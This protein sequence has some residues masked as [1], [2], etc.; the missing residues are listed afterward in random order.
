MRYLIAAAAL[1]GSVVIGTNSSAGERSAPLRMTATAYCDK[2]ATK[3]GVRAQTGVVAAD[4]RRLPLGTTLRIVAPREAPAGVYV[5]ADTGSEITGR[6]LDIFMPSC[7]RA[8]AFGK[9][10]VTVRILKLGAGPKAARREMAGR[11]ER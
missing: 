6:D 7:A 10:S 5:V 9:R 11:G 8:K 4:P 3:S 2:G 1:I